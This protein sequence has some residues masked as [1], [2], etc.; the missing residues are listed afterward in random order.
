MRTAGLMRGSGHAARAEGPSSGRRA[1][2]GRPI[3]VWLVPAIPSS[4]SLQVTDGMSAAIDV[5]VHNPS[6]LHAR[7]AAVFVKAA[8]A[9]PGD[10]RVANL[11]TGSAEVSAKSILAVLGLGVSSGHRIRLRVDGDGEVAAV[12]SLAD[13][14]AGGLGEA[15]AGDA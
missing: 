15:V 3:L 2:R 7:P 14:V 11:T 8:A 9:I 1:A 6:G 5:E 12:R 10:V 13:L 4:N